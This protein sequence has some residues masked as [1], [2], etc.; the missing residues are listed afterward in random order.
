[1]RHEKRERRTIITTNHNLQ[2]LTLSM[3]LCHLAF[4]FIFLFLT[5]FPVL[6]LEESL[7]QL[8]PSLI[9]SLPLGFSNRSLRPSLLKSPRT[10]PFPWFEAKSPISAYQHKSRNLSEGESTEKLEVFLPYLRFHP[11]VWINEVTPR[12]GRGALGF[13]F[14]G[15]RLVAQGGGA[16][17][18][19]RNIF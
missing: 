6:P 7:S 14:W 4:C 9:P 12:G 10:L 18:S 13:L 11:S 8:F 16:E 19:Y 15:C 17:R 3:F 5:S 1:M 2:L